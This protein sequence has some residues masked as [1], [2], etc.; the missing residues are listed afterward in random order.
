MTRSHHA[1]HGDPGELTGI[2]GSGTERPR[3]GGAAEPDAAVDRARTASGAEAHN[4]TGDLRSERG[5][6]QIAVDMLALVKP[7]I[8]VMA[9]LTAAGA[10]SL[11]PGDA[12]IGRAAWLIIGTALIVGSA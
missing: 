5:L 4:L 12:P 3:Q 1:V 2:E 6:R 10:M 8:M 11:A 7:R 9:L